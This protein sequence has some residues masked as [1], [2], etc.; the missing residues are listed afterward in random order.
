MSFVALL[1]YSSSKLSMLIFRV[2]DILYNV[3]AEHFSIDVFPLHMSVIVVCGTPLV[4]LNL[5]LLI[6]LS[7]NN[8]LIIIVHSSIIILYRY[9]DIMSIKIYRKDINLY[10]ICSYI[11]QIVMI[12]II[13]I[14]FLYII[15]I[16]KFLL[17]L[18]SV[19]ISDCMHFVHIKASSFKHRVNINICEQFFRRIYFR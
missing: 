11:L 13:N 12:F 18:F 8:S 1:V 4:L 14:F 3:S 19:I 15:H 7:F 2:F 5:Y 17:M 16:I 6:F 10:G 9:T